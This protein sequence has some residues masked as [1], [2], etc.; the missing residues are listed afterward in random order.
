MNK[1]VDP[2]GLFLSLL[3]IALGATVGSLAGDAR[4]GLLLA[5][6]LVLAVNWDFGGPGRPR[7]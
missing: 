4:W 2:Q 6:L 1:Q 5:M 7:F 3:V